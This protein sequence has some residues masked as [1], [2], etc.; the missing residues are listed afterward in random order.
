MSQFNTLS[1]VFRDEL[2]EMAERLAA[3][4]VANQPLQRAAQ[5]DQDVVIR[6]AADF[7]ADTEIIEGKGIP[8]VVPDR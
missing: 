7:D 1:N 2:R 5:A 6:I 3:K 8:S 4:K